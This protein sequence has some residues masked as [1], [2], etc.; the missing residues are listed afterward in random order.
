M[1]V[2][3]IRIVPTPSLVVWSAN[4]P[5]GAASPHTAGPWLGVGDPDDDCGAA[6]VE[7]A[8]ED[9]PGVVVAGIAGRDHPTVEGSAQ[10]RDRDGGLHAAAPYEQERRPWCWLVEGPPVPPS[11]GPAV[12]RSLPSAPWSFTRWTWR[13]PTRA[14][15]PLTVWVGRAMRAS[16][17]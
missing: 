9:R 17:P 1:L 2:N 11:S 7:A 4:C 15:R 12:H 8:V 16:A 14:G 6:L 3:P 13:V 10:P 5:G